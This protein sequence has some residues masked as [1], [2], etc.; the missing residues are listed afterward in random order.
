MARNGL[1]LTPDYEAAEQFLKL[2]DPTT[3]AFTFQ[4]FDDNKKR[5]SGALAQVRHGTLHQHRNELASSNQGGAGIYFAVNETDLNGRKGENIVRVRAV[6][7]DDDAGWQG[8]FPIPPHIVVETSPGKFQRYWLVTGLTFDEHRGVM[9]RIT[10]EFGND[11]N[12]KDLPRVLRLPGFFHRKGA[13]HLVQVIEWLDAPPYT[14]DQILAAFP[15]IGGPDG[16]GAPSRSR[17]AAMLPAALIPDADGVIPMTDEDTVSEETISDLRSALQSITADDR[18]QWVDM[19]H[20]LRTLGERGRALWVEWSETSDKYDESD[21]ARVWDSITAPKST[22]RA[23]FKRAQEGGWINPRVHFG[24]GEGPRGCDSRSVIIITPG[25]VAEVCAE[26]AIIFRGADAPI[27][28]RGGT[29]VRA[30]SVEEAGTKD[31]KGVRR[32]REAIVLRP[33]T[34][35]MLLA[36][37]SKFAEL[38]KFNEHRKRYVE[39]DMPP[40]TASAFVAVS[41]ELSALPALSGISEVPLMHADGTLI[42][43]AGYDPYTCMILKRGDWSEINVPA[44][45]TRDD[46]IAA[47][48]VLREPLAGFPFVGDV[49]EAVALS[50]MIS[51]VLRSQQRTV[52]LHAF[53]AT[54]PGTGKSLLAEVIAIIATGH[55]AAAIAMSGS[56]EEFEKRLD[57]LVLEG[58]S[59][60]LIDNVSRPLEGDAACITLT[61]GEVRV[62][63]LGQSDLIRVPCTTFWMATGNNLAARGD[64][65]RRLVRAEMDAKME[66]PEQRKFD[67]DLRPWTIANRM[68]LL[69]AVFTIRRWHLQ[70]G[71]PQPDGMSPVGSFEDWSRI[72]RAPLILLSCADPADSMDALRGED[73]DVQHRAAILTA[74]YAYYGK[75][76]VTVR[77]LGELGAVSLAQDSLSQKQ[78][79]L[80]RALSTLGRTGFIDQKRLVVW[81]RSNNGWIAGG[82]RLASDGNLRG[83]AKWS[84]TPVSDAR[85]SE[86]QD[87]EDLIG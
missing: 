6:W 35:A 65:V 76:G 40:S 3:E 28:R 63:R 43:R 20:A 85:A 15:P 42:T 62:R 50:G 49:S 18:D 57:G 30:M 84:V 54:A 8:T 13:S 73:I 78:N 75:A 55:A 14:R 61:A 19:A 64:M 11:K 83:G 22:Y 1:D 7:Q 53:S 32:A 34:P 25:K 79:E 33:L 58:D 38:R 44:R 36:D 37:A 45:P 59:V 67:V 86:H 81:L 27:Y 9:E 2:L 29:A 77:E 56:Q 12:A 87:M 52:P 68:R 23:V 51:A 60:V 24:N 46:A 47:L 70:A 71:E 82:L 74:W 48:L 10:A 66:R 17:A 72:V 26:L 41:G 31:D 39:C 5:K 80:L 4:T 69:S 21:A 16:S